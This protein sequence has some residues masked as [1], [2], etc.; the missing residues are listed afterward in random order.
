MF[1]KPDEIVSVALEPA[2]DPSTRSIAPG[3][4]VSAP[5]MLVLP[6]ATNVPEFSRLALT[7]PEFVVIV[8]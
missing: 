2:F 7:D 1:V 8:P 5:V 3:A 4:V 6:C